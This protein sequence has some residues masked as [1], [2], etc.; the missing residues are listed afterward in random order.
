MFYSRAARGLGM[1]QPLNKQ[2]T[3]RPSLINSISS[4]SGIHR[5]VG[6]VAALADETVEAAQRRLFR[7]E[8]AR[9]Q[10]G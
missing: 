9:E 1:G 10:Y 3:V 7:V 4:W 2:S 5:S 8:F 6:L